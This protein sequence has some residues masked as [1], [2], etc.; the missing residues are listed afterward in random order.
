MHQSSRRLWKT[1]ALLVL[2]AIKDLTARIVK[3]LHVCC[4]DKSELRSE[5]LQPETTFLHPT[6][7]SSSQ[8]SMS[9]PCRECAR[10]ETVWTHS[11][12]SNAPARP[13]GCWR[14]TGVW[15]SV[16]LIFIPLLDPPV[17]NGTPLVCSL[18]FGGS[19]WAGSVLPDSVWVPGLRACAA[20]R[21]DPGDVLLHRRQSLG[22]PLWTVSPDG[23]RWVKGRQDN[24]H[25]LL[26]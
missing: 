11:A 21:P 19:G 4:K 15:V 2:K 26:L 25:F 22:T 8:T 16:W 24:F 17:R 1:P 6:H 23:H 18:R 20:H 3:V 14:G 12:V 5:I 9:A 10:T 7:P 13:G